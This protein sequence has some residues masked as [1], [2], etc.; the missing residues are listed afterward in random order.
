MIVKTDKVTGVPVTIRSD[1]MFSGEGRKA[2][3]I[4]SFIFIEKII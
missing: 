4:V 3:Q 2:Q 1:K